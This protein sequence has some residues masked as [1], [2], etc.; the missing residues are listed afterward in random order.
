MN[1]LSSQ[2]QNIIKKM[3]SRWEWLFEQ[4]LLS[5]VLIVLIKPFMDLK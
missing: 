3:V 4:L 1:Q 5:S 2:N